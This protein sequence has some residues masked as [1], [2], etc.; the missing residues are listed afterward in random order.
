MSNWKPDEFS[1]AFPD[2]PEPLGNGRRKRSGKCSPEAHARKCKNW[3]DRH[4]VRYR[5]YQRRY[6]ASRRARSSQECEE[7]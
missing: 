5:D 2:D 6:Q 3:R 1:Q 7:A 4:S